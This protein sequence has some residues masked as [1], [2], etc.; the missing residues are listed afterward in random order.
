MSEPTGPGTRPDLDAA[1]E[2]ADDVGVD[3]TQEEIAQYRRL[4]GDLPARA[5]DDLG[6]A[7]PDPSVD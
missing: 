5:T 4:A 2:Y 3:P 1:E 7:Q 6:V